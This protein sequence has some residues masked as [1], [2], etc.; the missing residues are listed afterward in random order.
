M[1]P[2]VEASVAKGGTKLGLVDLLSDVPLVEVS[3]GQE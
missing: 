2:S 3:S 1:Y